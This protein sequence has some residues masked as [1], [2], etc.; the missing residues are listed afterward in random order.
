MDQTHP[1]RRWMSRP[2]S[3][4]AGFLVSVVVHAVIVVLFVGV[5]NLLFPFPGIRPI[6]L[7]VLPEGPSRAEVGLTPDGRL[8]DPQVLDSSG[9]L[10]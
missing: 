3:L 6:R 4:R 1:R 2:R 10:R 8:P 9:T 5:W 7:W